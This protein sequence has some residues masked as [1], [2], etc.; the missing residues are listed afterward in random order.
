MKKSLRIFISYGRDEHI[1][2]SRSLKDDLK[3]RGHDV[4]FDEDCLMPGFDWEAHIEKGLEWCSE[5]P[6][7]GRVILLMTPHS[8]RR[9]DGYC[10]NEITRALCRKVLIIPIM[11][12]WCEPPLS[13]CR[14]QWLDMQDC[15]PPSGRRERY[16]VKRDRLIEALEQGNLDFESGHS[17]LL[18]ELRPL[19]FAADIAMHARAFT[20][21]EWLLK[22]IKSWLSDNESQ[23][24]FW[25][26]GAP[27]V[28]KTAIA[29]HLCHKWRQVA[30]FHLCSFGHDDKADPRRCVL[31][32][33][34]QLG[35]Q[36][37]EYRERL[38]FLLGDLNKSA[39]S[40]FDELLVQP[41]A[42]TINIPAE[43][44]LLVIDGLDEA[45]E[46]GKNELAEFIAKEFPKTP[47]WLKL[48]ITSR[49]EPVLLQSLQ[50]YLPYNLKEDL[51]ENMQ[52]LE[53]F[54]DDQ[55]KAL[56]SIIRSS[57]EVSKAILGR[58]DGLFLYVERALT[59][60]KEHRLTVEH[61]DQLP[62]G[63][64]A[65]YFHFFSRQFP[66]Q[67]LYKQKYRPLVEMIIAAREPLPLALAAKALKWGP[68]DY[69]R[70][71]KGH[72]GGEA[73]SAL[74]ALFPHEH[75]DIR[76]F[77]RSVVDWLIDPGKS[78]G[79][80][81]DIREGHIRL[82]EVC[83]SEYVDGKCSLF[84]YSRTHLPTHL[85]ESARW[86]DL[87]SLLYDKELDLINRWIEGQG[88]ARA[89]ECLKGV[90]AYL[91]NEKVDGA[92][93]A[94]LATQLARIY[95]FRGEYDTCRYWLDYALN[96]ASWF[97]GRRA[98]IVAL[99]E[100]G[101]NFLYQQNLGEAKRNY[102][103]ALRGSL[104]CVPV[105]HGEAAANLIG[106]ATIGLISNQYHMALIN[107]KRAIRNAKASDDSLHAIAGERIIVSALFALGQYDEA[108]MHLQHALQLCESKA[109]HARIERARLFL[110][111]G[112]LSYELAVLRRD[113]PIKAKDY[114][115]NALHIAETANEFYCAVESR[116]SLSRCTLFIGEAEEALNLILPV[117][118]IVPPGKHIELNI[119]IQ[120]C[121]AKIAHK[122][123]A[124]ADA[125]ALYGEVVRL[126]KK[127]KIGYGFRTALTG[128]G[129]LYWHRNEQEKAMLTWQE[130]KMEA[131]KI[132]PAKVK[133]VEI[134]IE[135][136]KA[137]SSLPPF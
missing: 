75:G 80:H 90:I 61:I 73:L 128:L 92:A 57:E 137:E 89:T 26:V 95:G 7:Q 91:E 86:E 27:G 84:H 64:G 99:H 119:G 41:L 87:L 5:I 43:P 112:W 82:A 53:R 88:G 40:L 118:E 54:L 45:T 114:F 1:D 50:Q 81:I 10:L 111:G 131:S 34:Y 62:Q 70:G 72:A 127:H 67:T 108:E 126:C 29:A 35:S 19:D 78:F 58:S 32:L 125:E 18:N 48:L 46:H 16:K 4:W 42:R 9:P 107:A 102:A 103:K 130:A 39:A 117:V 36:F 110:A 109:V 74:G 14:I 66:D 124:L 123:K 21:R 122:R 60:L 22:D 76:P 55:L 79:Y 31:S 116:V 28:G 47:A 63:L 20:G 17:L 135:S 105:D 6:G 68:Y 77:H 56:A 49:P 13:I 100:L 136:C 8:V 15:T 71:E 98:K 65:D 97:K 94:G 132:S 101:S 11:V 33:A 25:L 85:M 69:C 51:Q 115:S 44:V 38:K 120:L 37:P 2:L 83:W 12:V 93:G 113:Q 30:A 23:R 96:R 121:L 129:A 133:I 3:G 24:V 134:A 59:G 106:L 104:W 52:D